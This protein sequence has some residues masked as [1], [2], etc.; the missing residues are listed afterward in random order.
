M[1]ENVKDGVYRSNSAH[2]FVCNDKV[3]MLLHGKYYQTTTNFMLGAEFQ[4]EL[5]ERQ[6]TTFDNVYNQC[7]KW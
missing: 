5:S 7:P 2:Y 4:H 1:A 3:M 6:K